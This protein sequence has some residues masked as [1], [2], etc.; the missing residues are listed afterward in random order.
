MSTPEHT[1]LQLLRLRYR[2]AHDAYQGCVRALSEAGIAGLSPP[3]ELLER[4]AKTARA[5]DEA[6]RTFM[7]GMSELESGRT[8]KGETEYVRS[9]PVN[10]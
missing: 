2:S 3:T 7:A 4:A 9:T 1:A 5:L 8:G 10:T 6:R